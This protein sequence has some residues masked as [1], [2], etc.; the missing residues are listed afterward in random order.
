MPAHCRHL[1][2]RRK[3]LLAAENSEEQ[4]AQFDWTFQFRTRKKCLGVLAILSFPSFA[5][6]YLALLFSPPFNF[7]GMCVV[8]PERNAL[9]AA[10]SVYLTGFKKRNKILEHRQFCEKRFDG[11]F[12]S[13]TIS[14]QDQHEEINLDKAGAR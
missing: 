3:T 5:L 4:C 10:F 9:Q 2:A 13:T 12:D 8:H 11:S 14:A 1:A 6:F 7:F